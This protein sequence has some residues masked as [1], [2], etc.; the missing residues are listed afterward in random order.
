[1]KII[2]G[3]HHTITNDMPLTITIGNFDGIHAGHQQLIERLMLYPDTKHA[4][5]TFDPHPLMTLRKN[6]IRTLTTTDDKIELLGAYV[7]D[8]LLVITFDEAF[9]TITIG[10]FI[11]FLERINVKRVIIG[12][13][14]RF[15]YKGE[16]TVADLEKVFEVVVV[17]DMLY[18][19]TR[20]SSSYIK[21]LIREGD[22][23][24]ARTLLNRTYAIKG[25]VVP[26]NSVGRSL[27]FPT[28][29]IDYGRYVVPKSG[30]YHVKVRVNGVWHDGVANIGNNPTLNYSSD[31]RLEVYILDFDRRIYGESLDIAFLGY[32]RPEMKFPD[33]DAL[34]RQIES[35]VESVRKMTM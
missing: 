24:T 15:G 14:A 17:D 31:V 21:D 22:V 19:H 26:G 32:L 20:V 13:D 10:D 11:R 18:H 35:D 8:M 29:N 23:K 9:S 12:R 4:V 30:V 7:I 2:K 25:T 27:G 28:A 33:K 1:M 34:I 5:M 3:P 16:G 6:D